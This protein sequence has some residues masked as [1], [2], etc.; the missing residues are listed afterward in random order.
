MRIL[1]T[2]FLACVFAGENLTA[3]DW[4]RFR[5]QN[6]DGKSPATG[7]MKNW[8]AKGPRLI[9]TAKNLG[10]GFSSV[11]IRGDMLFTIGDI[12]SKQYAFAIAVS[13]GK[14]IWKQEIGKANTGDFPGSRST[15]TVDG[16]RVYCLTTDATLVCLKSKT[17]EVLWQ[18]DLVKQY[19]AAMMLAKGKWEWKFSE[20]PLVD[21]ERVI[22]TPGVQGAVMVALNKKTGDEIWRCKSSLVGA[23]GADGA[24]YSSI[25]VSQA[26]G[27]KQYVQL[28]GRGLIGVEAKTG[29]LLWQY[30]KVA[31]DIANISNPVVTG[32]LVFVSTGYQT[33]SALLELSKSKNGKFKVNEKYF[34]RPNVFQ[35]H[36]G[37]FV[38]HDGFIYG[39]QGH[40]K[41]LPMCIRLRDGKVMWGPIRNQGKNSAAVC[42]A[43]G[44][45]YFRYQNG[46]M[47]LIEASASKYFQKSSFMIPDVR[48]PSWSH[49][50]IC[51]G[52]LYLK[53]QQR[54]LC[55]EISDKSK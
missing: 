11:T 45:L 33:G 48:H 26:C 36:H 9:W 38:L 5:G 1:L 22:V 6:G 4:L 17:G 46:L 51:N 47:V 49:P 40:K 25:V 20:S 19:G 41:G 27:V 2:T 15:P 10:R 53:E 29:K 16:D 32:D 21:G 13:D 55:Y 39:G 3:Q 8:P 28:V 7:L 12:D 30:N 18:K 34:L 54:V 42:F 44:H 52:R 35:N 43:D 31:N 50:V 24:A 37:G 14:Q 23:K